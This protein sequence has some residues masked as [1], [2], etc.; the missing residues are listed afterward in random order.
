MSYLVIVGGF[1]RKLAVHVLSADR[2]KERGCPAQGRAW[3]L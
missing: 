3:R 1:A 2:L